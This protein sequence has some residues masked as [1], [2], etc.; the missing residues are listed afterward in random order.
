[1]V[2]TMNRGIERKLIMSGAVWN[3]FTSLMTLFGYYRWFN[4]QGAQALEGESAELTIVGTSL[5]G[6]ISRVIL[7]FGLFMLIIA[8]INFLVGV[9]LKDNQIQKKTMVWLGIWVIIQLICTD[10]IGFLIYLFAFIIYLAKN[11]AVRLANKPV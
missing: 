5:V 8:I 2:N 3:L 4:E 6:N 10:I 1:M 9:H 11:K 7:A